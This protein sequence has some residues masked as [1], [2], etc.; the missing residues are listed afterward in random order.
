MR[1]SSKIQNQYIAFLRGINVGGNSLVKMSTIKDLL[2]KAGY[3]N[4]QTI[5]ASG[6]ICLETKTEHGVTLEH[7][8]ENLFERLL[9]KKIAVIVRSKQEI[10]E[11]ISKNP[12]P[13]LNLNKNQRQ[14]ISFLKSPVASSFTIAKEWQNQDIHIELLTTKDIAINYL[15]SAKQNTTD[16]MKSVEKAISK[17]ITSRNWNTVIKVHNLL[18]K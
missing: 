5:L 2:S 11:L 13:D 3:K 16:I 8:L 9:G 15:L 6:N 17:N 18:N 10:S 1:T 14:L 12:F 7:D 4:V